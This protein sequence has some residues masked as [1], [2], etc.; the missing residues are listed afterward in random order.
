MLNLTRA[1]N[2]IA[3]CSAWQLAVRIVSSTGSK[4]QA[5]ITLL[6]DLAIR[7]VRNG[8]GTEHKH[9]LIGLLG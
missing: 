4:N 5:L 2:G 7:P 8:I 6:Y 1:T 3:A 9:H